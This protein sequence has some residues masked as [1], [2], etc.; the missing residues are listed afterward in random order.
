MCATAELTLPH[1]RMLERQF[2]LQPL[3]D[4]NPDL[5]VG[6]T[7]PVGELVDRDNP[8]VRR[9]GELSELVGEAR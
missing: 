9:L 2:V 5:Q 1:P 8:D 4:L 7:P 3:A 6:G